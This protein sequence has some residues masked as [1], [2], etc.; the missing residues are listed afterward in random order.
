MVAGVLR[1]SAVTVERDTRV[2]PATFSLDEGTKRVAVFL[3]DDATRFGLGV[4]VGTVESAALF[5]RGLRRFAFMDILFL[6]RGPGSGAAP[7]WPRGTPAA[8]PTDL[9]RALP[10]GVQRNTSSPPQVAVRKVGTPNTAP[11]GSTGAV[12]VINSPTLCTISPSSMPPI[13]TATAPPRQPPDPSR[14]P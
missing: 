8:L 13:G 5:L 12:T 3:L 1:Q 11:D 9:Q 7:G 6:D 2:E 10:R 4:V 14:P